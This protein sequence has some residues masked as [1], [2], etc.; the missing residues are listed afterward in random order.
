MLFVLAIYQFSF[1]WKRSGATTDRLGILWETR[2]LL[3]DIVQ[4]L[5]SIV[6]KEF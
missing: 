5:G 2:K 4:S 3:E 6:F 1:D